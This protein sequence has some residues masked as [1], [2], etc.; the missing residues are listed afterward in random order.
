MLTK[1]VNFLRSDYLWKYNQEYAE[2][3]TS[4]KFTYLEN[5]YIY[6]ILL[7]ANN[8]YSG[9]INAYDLKSVM[10]HGSLIYH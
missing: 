5:L 7:L 8:I 6:G 3:V 1:S 9:L 4:S 2:I 10:L